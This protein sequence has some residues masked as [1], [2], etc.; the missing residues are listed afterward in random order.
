MKWNHNA[1]LVS[2]CVEY[3]SFESVIFSMQYFFC[4]V[5]NL[6]R[7]DIVPVTVL[8]KGMM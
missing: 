5:K 7:Y 6:Y 1:A 3:R 2:A 4:S 8:T